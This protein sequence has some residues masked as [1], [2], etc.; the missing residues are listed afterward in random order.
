VGGAGLGDGIGVG[1]TV[2]AVVAVGFV[3]GEL[4]FVTTAGVMV[5]VG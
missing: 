1:V 2:G 4:A 3:V 5:A